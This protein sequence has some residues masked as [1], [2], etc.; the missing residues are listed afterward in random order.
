MM[1]LDPRLGNPNWSAVAPAPGRM[2]AL[3]LVAMPVTLWYFAWLLHPDRIG[4]PLLFGVLIVAELF[5]ATQAAGFLW[6]C[7][8]AKNLRPIATRRRNTPTVDVFIPVYDEPLEVVAPTVRA[9]TRMRGARVTV[10]VLDDGGSDELAAFASSV[11]AH[12]LRRSENHGAKAG[13]INHALSVTSGALVAVFDCDHVPHEDFLVKTLPH[14]TEET[15]LVQT[16]QYYANQDACS[17]A[18]SAWAQQ[19]LF[20]GVIARGKGGAGSM[21]CCG[22]NVLFRRRALQEVRGFPEESLTEDFELSLHLHERGWK[23]AYVPEVLAQGLGPED[24]A[25]YVGQQQRWS[26]GCLSALPSILRARIPLRQ[27]FQYLLSSMYFLSGWTVLI[28]MSLPVIRITTGAQ[29]LAGASADAFL[30]HFVPYFGFALL[31]VARAGSGGYS[32]GAFALSAAS[33]WIHVQSSILQLLGKRGRFVVTPKR[34]ASGRQPSTALPALIAVGV[35]G[36]ATLLGLAR[37]QSPATLNNVAFAALHISVLLA[38][39]WPALVGPRRR[40][41]S[42]RERLES[43]QAA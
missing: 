39:S 30:F 27:R 19:A 24:M 13:N 28:Y 10:H 34:G 25:S 15:A 7:L 29:P 8:S 3:A 6:T 11:G 20:F 42:D 17:L 26:R 32:F 2:R 37:S 12:Y 23:T 4:H 36:V 43:R 22:T 21:F 16:P 1:D 38:G 35:L 33:F 18:S 14:L 31:N 40:A 9:A 5:N 41:A